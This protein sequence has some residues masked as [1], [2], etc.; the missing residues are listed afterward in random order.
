MITNNEII[1]ATFI[2]ENLEIAQNDFPEKMNWNDAR[3]ACGALGDGWR[4]PSKLELNILYENKTIIGLF[5]NV[6]YWS[7]TE[8]PGFR[9]PVW[10]LNFLNGSQ[11]HLFKTSMHNVRAVRILI[12][13]LK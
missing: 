11:Y 9:Y 2:V 10:V 5:R 4:L 1:G 13:N 6:T 8:Y 12:T 3:M 7:S